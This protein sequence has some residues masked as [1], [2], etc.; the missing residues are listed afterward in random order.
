MVFW[1]LEFNN[2]VLFSF[3]VAYVAFH[4]FFLHKKLFYFL[5][6]SKLILPKTVPTAVKLT[7][8]PL[9]TQV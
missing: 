8:C 2:F 3:V 1:F 4:C 6:Y 7:Q 5:I 9:Y